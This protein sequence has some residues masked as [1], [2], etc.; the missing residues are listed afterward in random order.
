[1]KI[2]S[3]NP[4]MYNFRRAG[5]FS[6]QNIVFEIGNCDKLKYFNFKLFR[7]IIAMKTHL[8]IIFQLNSFNP[9]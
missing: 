2:L 7:K 3:S 8:K 4:I 9:F 5:I 1:M 6:R